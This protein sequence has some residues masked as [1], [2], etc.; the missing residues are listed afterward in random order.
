MSAG[1]NRRAEVERPCWLRVMLPA[2]LRRVKGNTQ[3]DAEDARHSPRSG[4]RCGPGSSLD[5][6]G[7]DAAPTAAK[8]ICAPGSPSTLSNLA[9]AGQLARVRSIKTRARAA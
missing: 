2:A 6:A 4:R 5:V 1:D 9:A 8:T 7:W 3:K